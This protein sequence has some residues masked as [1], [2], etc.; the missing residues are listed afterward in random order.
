MTTPR[1]TL[2]GILILALFA[3]PLAGE[4][5]P[6]HVYRAGVVLLGDPYSPGIDGLRDDFRALGLEEGEPMP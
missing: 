6:A 1:L 4:A 2:T 5:Q 3:L